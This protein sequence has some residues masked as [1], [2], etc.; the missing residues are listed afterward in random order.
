MIKAYVAGPYSAETGNAVW[1]NITRARTIAESLWKSGFSVF[2]PHLNSAHMEGLAPITSYYD[3][4]I[5]WLKCAE[6]LV[7]L[8]GW[9]ASPGTVKEFEVAADS[10]LIM[11]EMKSLAS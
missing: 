3:G 8:E 10:N 7:L 2:C 9:E 1:W 4:D 11:W 5:E 6:L